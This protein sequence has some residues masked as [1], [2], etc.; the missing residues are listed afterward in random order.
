M[1]NPNVRNIDGLPVIMGQ[2]DTFARTTTERAMAEIGITVVDGSFEKG[3]TGVTKGTG[4]YQESTGKVFQWQLTNTFNITAGTLP[5]DYGTIGTDWIDCSPNTL[6]SDINVIQKRFSTVAEMKAALTTTDIG[7]V[8]EWVGYYSI[9]DGGGNRGIVVAGGTGTDDGGSYFD[10]ESGVQVKAELSDT[11]DIRLFGAVNTT[12][13]QTDILNAAISGRT[14]V[15]PDGFEINFS[16]VNS[17]WTTAKG[18]TGKGA[19]RTTDFVRIVVGDNFRLSGITI[20]SDVREGLSII[21]TV[22]INTKSTYASGL[23]IDSVVA[24]NECSIDS[25]ANI[26]AIRVEGFDKPVYS[27]VVVLR[28]T[29]WQTGCLGFSLTNSVIDAD[30]AGA[31]NPTVNWAGSDC[32]KC[33][34]GSYGTIGD[35][36]LLN[37]GRDFIDVY[38]AGRYVTITGVVGLGFRTEGIEIKTTDIV[39]GSDDYCR[40]I[41]IDGCIFANGGYDTNDIHAV[42]NI[43]DDTTSKVLSPRN[44]QMN[45]LIMY[46]IASDAGHGSVYCGAYLYEC[47]NVIMSNIIIDDLYNT[48]YPCHGVYLDDAKN[49]KLKDMYILGVK[50]RGVHVSGSDYKIEGVVTG[51]SANHDESTYGLYIAG[52]LIDSD[53]ANNRF[54]A[55]SRAVTAEGALI[56]RVKSIGD[57][58]EIR[59]TVNDN[60]IRLD[61]IDGLT[62]LV[63]TVLGAYNADCV[64]MTTTLCHELKVIAPKMQR[65]RYGVYLRNGVK[66]IL[67]DGNYDELTQAINAT[68]GVYNIIKNNIGDGTTSGFSGAVGGGITSDNISIVHTNLGDYTALGATSLTALTQFVTYHYIRYYAVS[69]PYTT[70]PTSYPDPSTDTNLTRF[71]GA[72]V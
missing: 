40:E 27:K 30:N 20:L 25:D 29:F 39:I 71:I 46:N 62:F 68:T 44:I 5:S 65:G 37:S 63:P 19:I 6:R 61:M 34:L 64:Y 57:R 45:N 2:L 53:L 8:V 49:V 33:T 35:V 31:Q 12:N 36:V 24:K 50:D 28:G 3:A 54:V 66:C 43:R 32:I 59:E 38:S 41:I 42:I 9:F 56:Q 26:I 1:T 55:K 67:V 52:T 51:A 7:K 16:A 23:V 60:C 47:Q 72:T 69:V 48:N 11:V 17:N 70:N 15:I 10:C 58:F 4:V 22:D 21:G 13:D 14:V 18:L